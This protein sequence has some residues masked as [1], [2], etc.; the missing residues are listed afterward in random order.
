M[1]GAVAA[2]GEA[3]V[4]AGLEV[5]K[6]GGNAAD[7]AIATVLAQTVTDSSMFCFGGEIPFLVYDA[8]RRVVEV[9]CG[10]GAAPLLATREY[11]A[12]KGGIPGSGVE[13]ATVPAVLDACLTVLDRY[14]TRTFA[15]SAAPVLVL[16][17]R[18]RQPW[19]ADLA[20]T[21]RTLI[22]AEEQSPGDRS[23]GL[24]LVADCFYRGSIAHEL[25]DWS[26]DSGGL[27]RYTDL[28][29]HCTRI[30]EPV[31][32][33]Y[34]GH[35]VYKCG[36]WTQGPYLLQT[37]RMLEDFDFAKSGHNSPATIHTTLEAMKLAL[38][39]R[40]VFYAD[41][42]F[43]DVPLTELLSKEYAQMRRPLID[44]NRASLE[45]RPGDPR[46]GKPLLAS[47]DARRG[48][49]GVAND[50]TTCVVADGSG[51]IIACTPS[52]WSGVVAGKTG[53]WLGSRLQSFNAWPGHPNCIEPGKRPRITLTPTLVLRE[54]K[55]VLAVSVAGGDGQDQTALQMV[56]N[57]IEFGLSPADSVTAPRFGTNHLLGSFGQ[58]P[59]SLGSLL[60]NSAVGPETMSRLSALGHQV[61]AR[62]SSLWTPC[63]IRID[64]GAGRIDAAGDPR[65]GRHAAAF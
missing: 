65:S 6:A 1:H 57:H 30:E 21:V 39:D 12:A 16:L 53:V 3:A 28:A 37:L 47:A 62:D 61:Q 19:H 58:S 14:G 36:A 24:R 22:A 11:F 27:I 43:A 31:K 23:R 60:I 40:D 35:T 4:N 54:G 52:G 26:R 25:D 32:I 42:D 63:V 7:A 56:L 55:P 8:K 13:A 50:T 2:G 15:Q 59:P 44:A 46:G 20:R 17:D 49:A 45:Q 29:T 41:P 10:Q 64:P 33:E 18:G 34:H 51:N 5:L 38:A 48:L 9:I